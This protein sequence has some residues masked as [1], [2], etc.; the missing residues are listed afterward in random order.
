M[1]AVAYG[2]EKA[3]RSQLMPQSRLFLLVLMGDKLGWLVVLIS[4]YF[5]Y[6]GCLN[7]KRVSVPLLK[8]GGSVAF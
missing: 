8:M 4:V 5:S 2:P 6:C 3:A 1:A 7:W